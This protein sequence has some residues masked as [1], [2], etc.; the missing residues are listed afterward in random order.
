LKKIY[1]DESA[2]AEICLMHEV[3]KRREKQILTTR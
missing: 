3:Q 2:F 1:F